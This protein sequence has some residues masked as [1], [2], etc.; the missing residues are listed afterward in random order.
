VGGKGRWLRSGK[1]GMV[2]RVSEESGEVGVRERW[3]QDGRI[4]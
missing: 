4:G 1:G 2:W 3:V